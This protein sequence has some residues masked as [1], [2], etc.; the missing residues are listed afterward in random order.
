MGAV[1]T[2]ID[3]ALERDGVLC[4]QTPKVQPKARLLDFHHLY[5]VRKYVKENL[6]FRTVQ[7]H[8]RLCY[9]KYL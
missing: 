7:P 6:Q 1:L 8:Q 4:V 5:F 3:P 9:K 2:S